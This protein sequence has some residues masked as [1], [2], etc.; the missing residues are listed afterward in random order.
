MKLLKNR[1]EPDM[2]PCYLWQIFLIL[3]QL[4][5][6]AGNTD[7]HA[8][9]MKIPWFHVIFVHLPITKQTWFDGRRVSHQFLTVVKWMEHGMCSLSDLWFTDSGS[10][11]ST[12][13]V[14]GFRIEYLCWL[15]IQIWV[16]D[17]TN[18]PPQSDS[19]SFQILKYARIRRIS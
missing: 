9:F 2:W 8:D 11:D 6:A 1:V 7:T 12:E 19:I 10:M 14:V 15:L 16:N 18:T 13:S 3:W 5:I 4:I 17:F